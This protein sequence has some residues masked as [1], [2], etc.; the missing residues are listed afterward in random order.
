[1][2]A[3][4]QHLLRGELQSPGKKH[5]DGFFPV[6]ERKVRVIDLIPGKLLPIAR[7]VLPAENG[8]L[9]DVRLARVMEQGA[10]DDA[11]DG[12]LYFQ[13][14]IPLDNFLPDHH[15]RL[16]YVEG[17][18][19]QAALTVEVEAG[20]SGSFEEPQFLKLSDDRLDT[21]P[22]CGTEQFDK[23]VLVH[24]VHFRLQR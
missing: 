18:F 16:V 23:S 14:W 3:D 2:P 17:V 19:Q 1:M 11:L 4:G 22:S 15:G 20:G 8:G 10:E 7:F 21:V 24:I 6:S 13:F 12:Q 5:D 9:V